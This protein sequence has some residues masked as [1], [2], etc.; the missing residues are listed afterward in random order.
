MAVA[1][2]VEWNA[3]SM[4]AEQTEEMYANCE[5]YLKDVVELKKNGALL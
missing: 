5:E 1:C 3:S 2:T 4:N